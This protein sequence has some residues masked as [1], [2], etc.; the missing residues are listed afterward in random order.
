[1][2][3]RAE[4]AAAST[5]RHFGGRSL[6]LPALCTLL[7][8]TF[9][10]NTVVSVALGSIQSDLH[11]GVSAL[12]W[13]VSAYALTFASIM[14][15]CGMIGDEFGRKKVML[16]GA[17]VFCAGSV[18][19]ALAPNVAVLIAGRAVMGLGAAASEPG[20]LSMLRQ[21]YTDEKSRNRAVGIW[22]AVTGLALA[23][24]PV[25]GGT[26]V[27]VWNWRG[28]FWFNLAFGLAAL[29][30]AGIVLP[31]SSDP[32][33]N[34][35]DTSGTFLGA[36]ALA[37]F[38]FGIIG[39]E[40]AGFDA[41]QQ[42]ILF[43]ISAIAAVAFFW[44]E[45]RAAHPLLDLKYL[46][47]ARFGTANVVAFCAYFA[48]FAIFFFTALY[49]AE[50]VGDTG[51][52]IASIFLPMTVLMIVASVLVGR[53][54]GMVDLRW[55]VP[56][57][58]LIFSAGLLLTNISL[59]PNPAYLPLAA[60]LALTGIGIGMTVVPITSSALT[61]VPPERSGMAASAT[62]TSREIGA[63][64]GVAVLGALVN[65]QLRSDLTGRLK[66]LGIPANFQSIVI[67]AIETGGVPSNGNK[68][69]A[70]GAA[71]AG[72]G[73]L[74]QEVI[75]AAYTAFHQ[76]LRAAL[77][78]S[79]G[80]VLAA[81]ILAALTLGQPVP[82]PGG[83]AGSGLPAGARPAGGSSPVVPDEQP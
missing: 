65:E 81:G 27:G 49:L 70:G 31:E 28:I 48:T 12:Q 43:S 64:T 46:R 69:G 55:L 51:F 39:A 50:V 38:V 4:M 68:A 71:G 75:N 16:S 13:V 67:H 35:V 29:V 83:E 9:L 17:G 42:I 76:G 56:T 47:I 24:G 44:R 14:L 58:C 66:H 37:A 20:T 8:L 5:R 7:F 61:A 36:A 26:L 59:S 54:E 72:Q 63:V 79:A 78:L 73:Q 19:C 30:V 6:A 82:A 34:R 41:P 11:A 77:F 62:N 45:H 1:V 60:S 33:A 23:A 10:D 21:L 74:V 52:G 57:G 22:A 2:E 53:W 32:D 40:S 18:M 3:L 25:V 15:A 80:L